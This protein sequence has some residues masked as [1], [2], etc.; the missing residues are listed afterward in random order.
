M[1]TFPIT[2]TLPLKAEPLSIEITKNPFSGVT[3]AVTL[4]LAIIVDI[5]ASGVR[6][7]R[8]ISNNLAP[9][10][11]NDEP[12]LNSIPPLTN[13]EPVNCEPLSND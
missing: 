12:E 3:D 6:A 10:P 5:N 1:V 9:L 4:P 2:L 7:E 8:G 13:N 11:L